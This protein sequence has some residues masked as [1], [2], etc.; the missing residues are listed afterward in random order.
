MLASD[1]FLDMQLFLEVAMAKRIRKKL[2]RELK[3]FDPTLLEEDC[4]YETD[5]PESEGEVAQSPRSGSTVSA[6]ARRLKTL[7]AKPLTVEELAISTALEAVGGG[8]SA[9]LPSTEAESVAVEAGAAGQRL[10]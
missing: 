10:R 5:D 2:S 1:Y 4:M 7:F 9:V 3:D 8:A 6:E